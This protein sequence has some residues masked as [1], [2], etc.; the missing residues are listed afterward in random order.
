M[1]KENAFLAENQGLS[2]DVTD[3]FD[4]DELEEKLQGQLEEELADLEFS[5]EEKEKIG[6]PDKLGEVILDEV[7]KQFGNQI[8]LDMTNETSIQKYDREHPETYDEVGKAVMRDQRYK[9]ANN[10]MKK[11]QQ[12]GNLKDKYTGKDIKR[13]E[14]A[15]LDHVVSR[16][17]LY[18]NQRRKQANLST[19]ELANKSENL[20]P[21]NESLNK[22]KGAKSVDEYIATRF[23]RERK[24][25]EQNER[26]NKKIDESKN[27]SET[28]KRLRKKENDKRLQDKLDADNE[29]MKKEDKKARKEINKDI[30][31]GAAKEVGKKAGKDALKQMVISALFSMLKEIMNG[32]VRF[33]KSQAKSFELFLDEMKQAIKSFFSKITSVLQTG[34]SSMV[35]TIVSEIFGPIVS[36]FKRLASLIKQSIASV[37][38]AVRYLRDKENK[39]KPFSVKVVQV[40]KIITVGLVA[41]GTIFLGELFEKLLLKIPG[42]QIQLPLIGSLANVIG[43][44]LASL[45]SGLVGAIVIN[46][47]DKFIA[48]KEK[49]EAIKSQVEKGNNILNTQH[50]IRIVSEVKLEHD[51]ANAANT[52]KER[53]VAAANMMS[54][55]LENIAANCK[56]DESIQTTFYDIDR[57]LDE[58]EDE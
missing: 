39:N 31:K 13:N 29:S 7:W 14:K 45:I 44:F 37:M 28:E 41:G 24:L 58:L 15:N 43:M 27:I 40:G 11:Q 48:K 9:D 52:I 34:A 47:I 54:E 30:A 12:A 57:L 53:H 49:A 32:L 3:Y 16:K 10:A 42:M 6:N 19:E 22:S 1:E 56:G 38:E 33:F 4:F 21:T 26:A 20:K 17:E 8:G 35:G 25:K 23:E 55:S 2:E 18:E 5:Q 50:Q 51:K 46:L 36:T